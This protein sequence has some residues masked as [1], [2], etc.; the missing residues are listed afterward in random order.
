M[1]EQNSNWLSIADVMS[2]LMMIFLFIAVTSLSEQQE[3]NKIIKILEPIK[4]EEPKVKVSF[5]ESYRLL[6]NKALHQEFDND[7]VKWQAEITDNNTFRFSSPFAL[8][9]SEIPAKFN[10][11]LDVFFPRYIRLLSQQQF[12]N[13]IEEVRVEGHTSSSWSKTSNKSD[14]YLLNMKLSQ[15]RASN[16]LA[17]VYNNADPFI[18]YKKQ[19]LEK[20]LRASGMAFAHLLYDQNGA[21]DEEKS[22]RVEFRVLTL[23]EG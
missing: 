4:V 2:A 15:K 19:W 20:Y 3:L 10:Q 13:E 22:R 12:K 1:E 5:K 21:E 23:T 16:V 8:G 11:V 14:N 7:L 9:S 17:L 18:H 6:L